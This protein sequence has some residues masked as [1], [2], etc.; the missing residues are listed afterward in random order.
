MSWK[1][2]LQSAQQQAS[3]AGSDQVHQAIESNW[4]KVQQLFLERVGPK[5][6]EVVSDDKLMTHTCKL[7]HALLPLPV[8]LVVKELRFIDFCLLHRDR[9]IA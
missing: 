9:F 6:H 1:Y 8:R 7:V 5:A 2:R 3:G 4:P